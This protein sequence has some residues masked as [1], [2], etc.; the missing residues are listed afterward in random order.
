[1][2]HIKEKNEENHTQPQSPITND[3]LV[4]TWAF[5]PFFILETFHFKNLSDPKNHQRGL[6]NVRSPCSFQS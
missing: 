2:T 4:V 3:A 6:V 1:M 5:C